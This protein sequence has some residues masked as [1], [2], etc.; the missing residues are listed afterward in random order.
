MV[1]RRDFRLENGEVRT[2]F[3]T[4]PRH[5]YSADFRPDDG[6]E[7]PDALPDYEGAQRRLHRDYVIAELR[8][9][10]YAVRSRICTR[11]TSGRYFPLSMDQLREIT[12]L[13]ASLAWG[14]AK[15]AFDAFDTPTLEAIRDSF[16]KHLESLGSESSPPVETIPVDYDLSWP[17]EAITEDCRNEVRVER[18]EPCGWWERLWAWFGAKA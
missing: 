11:W 18:C 3:S 9:A 5:R 4:M 16:R 13:E 2:E 15:E 17:G 10:I 12:G 7:K 6:Q 1:M 14:I 8:E